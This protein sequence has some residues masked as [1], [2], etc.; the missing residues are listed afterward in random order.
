MNA[1][2]YFSQLTPRNRYLLARTLW[3]MFDLDAEIPLEGK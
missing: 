2:R 1:I 3:V